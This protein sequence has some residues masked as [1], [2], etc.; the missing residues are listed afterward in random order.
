M[1]TSNFKIYFQALWNI[2]DQDMQKNT[3]YEFQA[4]INTVTL[5]TAAR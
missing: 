5:W 2:M 1:E 4:F 3:S